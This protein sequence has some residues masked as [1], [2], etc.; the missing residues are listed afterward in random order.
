MQAMHARASRRIG[1]RRSHVPKPPVWYGLVIVV[2]SLVVIGLVMVLS[3]SSVEAQRESGSSLSYFFRQSLWTVIGLV[4]FAVTS[5][6]DYR[7]WRA[8]IPVLLAVSFVLLL[9]VLLPGFGVQVNGAR[10]WLAIGPMSFQPAELMKLAILLYS[11]DLLARRARHMADPRL[12]LYPVLMVVGATAFVMMLQ[13]DLGSTIVIVGIA[14]GVLFVSGVPLGRLTAWC[15]AAG[16]AGTLLAFSAKYRRDRLLSF[17]NP[18]NSATSAGYQLNQSLTGIATGGLFGVGLGESKAKWGFLPNAHTDFIYAVIAEELGLVGALV[19]LLLF[20]SLAML[21]VKTA[22]EAPDRF[23][24]YLAAGITAWL[25]AQ[26][27][28]NIGGV[29][30][31]LPITGLTLP[32]VSFGGSSLLVTLATT[33]MLVNIAGTGAERRRARSRAAHPARKPA[34]ASS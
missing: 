10:S 28:V 32:F 29:V 24:C 13:P 22:L 4:A 14:F 1:A 19:V 15:T 6:I 8:V 5:R 3:A 27:F 21:G 12:T 17:L 20:V 18:T 25:L 34:M 31:L 23:G 9:A 16:F 30:G 33:G 26:A 7:R 11:A 2:G